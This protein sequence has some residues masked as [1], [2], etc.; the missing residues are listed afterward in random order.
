VA[1]AAALIALFAWI[2]RRASE[3]RDAIVP[4]P[5]AAGGAGRPEAKPGRVASED[6]VEDVEDVEDDDGDEGDV[7]AGEIAITSDGLAFVPRP[8]SVLITT[9]SEVQRRAARHARRRPAE[10][11]EEAPSPWL[12]APAEDHRPTIQLHPGDLIA[13]RVAR[14]APDLDPWRLE[15]LGRDRD[16]TV[17]IFEVEEAAEAAR[18][19]LARRIVRPPLD[20]AGEPIPVGD[21]DF[22]AAERDLERTLQ[23]LDAPDEPD[24]RGPRR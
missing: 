22:W 11:G 17:W 24:D 16:L 20:E 23:E 13:V 12:D 7:A 5:A 19:L 3:D 9:A 6:D 18:E 2:L 21:E 4:P 10:A 14:G 15:T 8:H 1:L